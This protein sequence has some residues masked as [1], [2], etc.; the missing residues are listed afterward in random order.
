M[1]LNSAK[2]IEE[3]ERRERPKTWLA[4][5]CG[6]S[7]PLLAYRLDKQVLTGVEAIARVLKVDLMDIVIV[8]KG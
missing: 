2:I 7:R 1:K 4:R 5:H 6:V 8:E 3:L